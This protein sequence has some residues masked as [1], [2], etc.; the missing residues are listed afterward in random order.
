MK[1]IVSVILLSTVLLTGN[2]AFAQAS[3][4]FNVKSKI[5]QNVTD[6]RA[7]LA[8]LAPLQ[9]EIR[10]NRTQILSLKAETRESYNKA[11]SNI[12][13]YMKNKDNLTSGEIES[14]KEELK[15]IQQDKQSLA[16]TIGQIQKE[17]L[18]LR[19][20][21]REK[22][23]DEVKNSLN[24]IIAIQDSRIKDLQGIIADLNEAAAL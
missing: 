21:K 20:A 11:K 7:K 18:D 22:N 15:V 24:S 12:K 4:L 10:T 16:G 14:L 1:K 23:F 6:N 2:I 8:E 5:S 17:T 13:Q 3:T 9:E 19:V